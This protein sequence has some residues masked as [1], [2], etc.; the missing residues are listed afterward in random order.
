MTQN[1]T[2]ALVNGG[3]N[4][5][6]ISKYLL[7]QIYYLIN[8]FEKRTNKKFELNHKNNKNNKKDFQPIKNQEK[9]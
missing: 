6:V 1:H 5:D 9:K 8:E 2:K 3:S 7:S 4:N